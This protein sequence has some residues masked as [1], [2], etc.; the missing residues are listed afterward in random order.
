ME[1][2]GSMQLSRNILIANLSLQSWKPFIQRWMRANIMLLDAK[3]SSTL[4]DKTSKAANDILKCMTRIAEESVPRSAENIALAVG[5]LCMVLPPSAHAVKSTASKFL[6]NW[7]SQEEH[8]YR[9]WS[10]AISLGVISSCL[11]VTDHKQKSE[12][13]NALLEVASITKSTLVKGACG[14]GLGFSCQDL[15][16]R[17]EVEDDSHMDKETYKMQ[18]TDLLRKIVRTLSQLIRPFAQ[19]SSD[20]LLGLSANLSR[21]STNT[22]LD[23]SVEFSIEHFEALEEDTWGIAG[24]V[25]GLGSS[26]SAVYRAG[27]LDAVLEIKN[28]IESWIPHVNPLV[29]N[30]AITI[31]EKSELVLSVGSCLALPIVV[32]FC[33]R[34]ELID[35]AELDQ[36]LQGCRELICELLCVKKSGAFHQSLLMASCVGVGSLLACI[37]NEGV[38]TMDIEHVIDVLALFKK[39]YSDP[40]PPLIHLGGMLGVVNALG[41]G[42]G[43]PFLRY[44]LALSHTAYDHK[45]VQESSYIMGPLL[46]TAVLEPSLTSSIQDIFLVAQNSDDHHLQQYAAWALSFL[47]HYLWSQ[48][49]QKEESY[50]QKDNSGTKSV[51]RSFPEDSIVMKLCLWLL[52]L[53]HP[54]TGTNPHVNTVA[55]SLRCLSHAPRLPQ[56]EWGAIIRRCMRYEDQA[57]EILREDS[58]LRKGILR[59]ESLAFSLAH[60]NQFDPLLTFLDELSDLSR[61]RIL[62][63]N[64]QSCIL[65]HLPD[66]VKIFSRSRLEKLFNDVASFIQSSVSSDQPYNQ[67]QKS[68]LRTSCWKGVCMCLDETSISSQE[69]IYNIE[70][71][72]E[73]L[74][75]LL[76][77]VSSTDFSLGASHTYS[78]EEWSEAVKC[79]GKARVDWLLD[80]L[81]I[82]EADFTEGGLPFSE[83]K[84][85]SRARARLVQIGSLPLIE[86]GKLKAYILNSR[87]EDIWD[88]LVE[89]AAV[90]QHVEGSVKKQWLVDAVEISCVTSYPYTALQFLGLLSGSFSKYMPLLIVDRLT[91]LTDLP[92]TLTSLLLEDASWS[93]MVESVVLHMWTSTVRIHDWVM[94]KAGA[95]DFSS[96]QSIHRSE[97]NMT[98]FLLKVMH[99]A[100]VSLK[101]FL[102]PD[103]QLSLANMVIP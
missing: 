60:A 48:E 8:E 13:I 92:V 27:C 10:A 11:H 86:L 56:L 15:L 12:N 41:A 16:T 77:E 45:V 34:V 93:T 91:V 49:V 40:R 53:N 37:L 102:P 68:L 39:A 18:E 1:I 96:Q 67:E 99:H 87:S 42:A 17:F 55:T 90:L 7:V 32:A 21:D 85:K 62:E 25:L 9:Q 64:L 79:L 59:E 51:S 4:V 47:R 35:S 73:V 6:L 54:E 52:H 2:A 84:K 97:A 95:D 75:S 58:S 63:M 94:Q 36:I 29:Q 66:L 23:I 88:V 83:A 22:D 78:M 14:A 76:P 98:V 44:P 65:L 72:M 19:S 5:A 3:S 100:C 57:A 26:I 70:N 71:C 81:Q 82:S 38:H 31:S 33:Q 61:F 50:I 20:A 24:L 30:S 101:D 46:S 74:F 43:T 28:L 69:Y 80:L 103:K 89:V